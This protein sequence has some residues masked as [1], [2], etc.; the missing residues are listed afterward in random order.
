MTTPA[1]IALGIGLGVLVMSPL[2]GI[3]AVVIADRLC[4]WN[5]SREG[6]GEWARRCPRVGGGAARVDLPVLS[7]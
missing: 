4:D 2:I 3:G 5:N 6:I 1:A 7:G